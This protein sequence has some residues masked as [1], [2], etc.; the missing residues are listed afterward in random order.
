MYAIRGAVSVFKIF[1]WGFMKIKTGVRRFKNAQKCM[2]F[3]MKR[4]KKKEVMHRNRNF[5]Q[6]QPEIIL[7][8]SITDSFHWKILW[9]F[10]QLKKKFNKSTL[11]LLRVY[12]PV[13]HNP[14]GSL[15]S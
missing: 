7:L 5:V 6:T 1:L 8:Q 14:A 13:S 12:R 3:L 15:F 9:I 10:A 4:P 2:T 11:P